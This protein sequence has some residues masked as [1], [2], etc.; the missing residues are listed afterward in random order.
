M[1][2]TVY[3]HVLFVAI[4]ALSVHMDN[5]KSILTNDNINICKQRQYLYVIKCNILLQ[6]TWTNFQ[7]S[8]HRR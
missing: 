1:R 5:V 6:A 3:V 7:F 2:K 4:V 8:P